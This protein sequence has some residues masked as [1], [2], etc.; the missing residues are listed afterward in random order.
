MICFNATSKIQIKS[1]YVLKLPKISADVF[2]QRERPLDNVKLCEFI[3][4]SH[5]VN[6][7]VKP[8]CPD[9]NVTAICVSNLQILVQI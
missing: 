8:P 3:I 6:M 5:G 4:F 2:I 1:Y 7:S 9:E